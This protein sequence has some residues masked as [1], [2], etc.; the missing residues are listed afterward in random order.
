MHIFNVRSDRGFTL[1]ET[2]I[3]L[4]L[5]GILAAIAVP[6]FLSGIN[7]SRLRNALNTFAGALTESQ[8]E[9]IRQSRECTLNIPS[10]DRQTLTGTCLVTG[11]RFLDRI[12]INRSATAVTYNFKGEVPSPPNA[13]ETVI[14]LSL[15]NE[16]SQ[17]KCLVVASGLGITRVGNYVGDISTV[18]ASNS[19]ITEP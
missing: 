19:C 13:G 4:L 8:R 12:T 3:I 5:V 16:T 1:V 17:P 2:I 10:G 15:T 18:L 11:D 6:S 9:A 7:R 14:V